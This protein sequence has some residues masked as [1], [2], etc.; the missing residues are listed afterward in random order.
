MACVLH[1]FCDDGGVG[2]F[3]VADDVAL[4][5]GGEGERCGEE[6]E[7]AGGELHF[8]VFASGGMLVGGGGR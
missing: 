3:G 4:V 7:R 1:R 5:L 8:L 6:D 2:A